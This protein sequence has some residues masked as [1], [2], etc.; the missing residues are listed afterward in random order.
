MD[1]EIQLD[2]SPCF[3]SP[4]AESTTSSNVEYIPPFPPPRWDAQGHIRRSSAQLRESAS[5]IPRRRRAQSVPLLN[6]SPFFFFPEQRPSDEI[7]PEEA[8]S[9]PCTA[10]P[11]SLRPIAL[12]TPRDGQST[13]FLSVNYRLAPGRSDEET[14]V[15]SMEPLASI[16][17]VYVVDFGTEESM[18]VIPAKDAVRLLAHLRIAGRQIHF[19][20]TH[21]FRPHTSPTPTRG[22]R[23]TIQRQ[24]DPVVGEIDP[25]F[26]HLTL[27]NRTRIRDTLP[28]VVGLR[29]LQYG[30]IEVICRGT[31]EKVLPERD[32]PETIGGLG[33]YAT[34]ASSTRIVP[35]VAAHLIPYGT[36]VFCAGACLDV[37]IIGPDGKAAITASTHAFIHSMSPES[38]DCRSLPETLR[39]AF[40]AVPWLLRQAIHYIVPPGLLWPV[41]ISQSSYPSTGDL[42]INVRSLWASSSLGPYPTG[43]NHDLCLI[44]GNQ[45]PE[46]V[47]LP[48][49]PRLE[50]SFL[51]YEQVFSMRQ[52]AIFT[53]TYP[54]IGA[55]ASAV[56]GFVLT[57]KTMDITTRECLLAG[58]QISLDNNDMTAESIL[59]RS[60]ARYRAKDSPHHAVVLSP[61][62]SE[63][64]DYLSATGFSGSVV[65]A[66]TE[67]ATNSSPVPAWARVLCFQNFQTDL[68]DAHATTNPSLPLSLLTYKG[69][70][71]LPD[72]IYASRIDMPGG[73]NISTSAQDGLVLR[74]ELAK[75]RRH[76]F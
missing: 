31:P 36:K 10:Y 11:S 58:T 60:K 61:P 18:W 69:G 49:L 38:A 15:R 55:N 73:V 13:S 62:V 29:I 41:P 37:K 45:L 70:F 46:I 44:R 22:I 25:R 5:A 23:S 9:T 53:V 20:P 56:R 4:S 65:C 24:A 19:R 17:V 39:D 52:R 51:P 68:P 76:S 71:R 59:W 21:V 34:Q 1:M 42:P 43:Y 66:G 14:S 40:L 30:E 7:A 2:V 6:S 63:D 50:P 35:S 26:P 48:L 75:S 67:L 74:E 54:C 28:F 3:P 16:E 57:G 27:K 12:R 47:S 64:G 8:R 72:Y 32:W 33:Y